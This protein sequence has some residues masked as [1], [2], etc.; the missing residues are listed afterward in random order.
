MFRK[1]EQPEKICALNFVRITCIIG[2][3]YKKKYCMHLSKYLKDM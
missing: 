1:T 2:T 3:L